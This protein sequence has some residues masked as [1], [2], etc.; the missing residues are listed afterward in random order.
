MDKLHNSSENL[1]R[2][3]NITDKEIKTLNKIVYILVRIF[4]LTQFDCMKSKKEK[5]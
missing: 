4:E 2:S 3:L 1:Q 5:M